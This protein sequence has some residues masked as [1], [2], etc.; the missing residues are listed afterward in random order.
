MEINFENILNTVFYVGAVQGIILSI[1]LFS[2]KSNKISNRLLG[3][4][5]FFWAIVLLVF[6]LQSH[7]IYIHFPHLLGVIFQL[8]FTWFPLLFLSI[9][10]LLSNQ[11][12]FKSTDFLHFLPMV[13]IILLYSEFY[14]KSGEE[15]IKLISSTEGYYYLVS[16]I[17]QEVLTLQGIIYPVLSLIML[18]NYRKNIVDYQ[19]NID[20]NVINGFRIGVT[21]AL[22]AWVIGAV[23]AHL[24]LF[25]VDIGIDLFL[26]VYLFFV[27]IIYVI[28][29]LAIRSPEVFKLKEKEVV[30]FSAK[31]AIKKPK[32]GKYY[33]NESLGFRIEPKVVVEENI[34]E[35]LNEKL[36]NKMSNEKPYL[37]PDLSLQEL[38]DIL[39]ISRHQL[40]ATINKYQQMNFY[41]FVNSYRVMEV[42]DLMTKPNNKNKKNYDLAF[43]A[44]FNSKA[45]FY[46]IFKQY[47]GLTPSD[48]RRQGALV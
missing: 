42:K 15:K 29:I 19:S 48:F 38:S 37:D 47:T 12:K 10:Y 16:I 27:A 43:E 17:G 3:I 30:A 6:A 24:E 5:T 4:L 32:L 11:E 26:F 39:G 33:E 2:V 23:G 40:S 25:K 31:K 14:F 35:G 44:G 22:I 41:E 1:F 28:S 20:I 8:L 13:I 34:Y 46:R 9:K 18:N 7:G 36:L 21:L 45:T